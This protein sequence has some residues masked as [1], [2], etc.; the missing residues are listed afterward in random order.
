MFLESH[1]YNR[2]LCPFSLNVPTN[3]EAVFTRPDTEIWTE[4]R[5]VRVLHC[6]NG[7][8]PKFGQNGCGTHSSKISA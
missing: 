2:A 4:I 8:G 3:N 5:P 6:V 7:D 1:P